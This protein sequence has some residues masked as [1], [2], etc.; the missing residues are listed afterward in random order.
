MQWLISS[1]PIV[2]RI[3]LNRASAKFFWVS[4]VHSEIVGGKLE[5]C[6]KIGKLKKKV[7]TKISL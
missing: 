2:H 1:N 7:R 3:R 5:K 6:E 4:K